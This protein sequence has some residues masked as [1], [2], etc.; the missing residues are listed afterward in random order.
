[1]FGAAGSGS[2]WV[3]VAFI[4]PTSID[5]PGLA[6]GIVN[7]EA[8]QEDGL[9]LSNLAAAAQAEARKR[10]AELQRLRLS[11]RQLDATKKELAD[12]DRELKMYAAT[13]PSDTAPRPLRAPAKYARSA[14]PRRPAKAKPKS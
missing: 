5:V 3:V 1:V 10:A 9:A 8:S 11:A 2:G 14:G 4:S 7:G 12:K 6:H 13:L